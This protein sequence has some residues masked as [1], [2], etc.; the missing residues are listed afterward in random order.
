MTRQLEFGQVIDENEEIKELGKDDLGGFLRD[1][2]KFSDYIR[3]WERD[4]I[5]V[6]D[7]ITSLDGIHEK[8]QI[9]G[10]ELSTA[11]AVDTG[12]KEVNTDMVQVDKGKEAYFA[13]LTNSSNL[14]S[15]MLKECFVARD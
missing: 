12:L 9:A 15:Q 1:I 8:L 4:N 2:M 5:D 3:N 13:R 11:L 6:S 7:S 14:L 10:K